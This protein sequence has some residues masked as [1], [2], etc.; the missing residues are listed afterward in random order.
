MG[1][2]SFMSDVAHSYETWL[3]H[4]RH[5]LFIWDM[6]HSYGTWLLHEWR[7]SSNFNEIYHISKV[8]AQLTYKSLWMSKLC[9]VYFHCFFRSDIELQRDPSWIGCDV[10]HSYATWLNHMRHDFFISDV[11][12]RT[13]KTCTVNRATHCNTL[14]RTATHCNTLQ[15]T[16]CATWLLHKWRDSSNFEDVYRES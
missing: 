10:T 5:D 14:Q 13:S 9:V 16:A 7:G 8:L 3:I 4:M 6:T 15:Y 1:H 11:T 2:D 12:H